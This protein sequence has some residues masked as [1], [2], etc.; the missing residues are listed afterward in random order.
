[1]TNF[2]FLAILDAITDGVITIDESSNVL[3]VNPVAARM[4]GYAPEE[5][6]G[7]NVKLLMPEP[8]A[9][10]HANYVHD[11][12]S[13]GVKHVLASAVKSTACTRVARPSP[14]SCRSAR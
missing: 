13:S 6:L 7:Q 5:L 10:V 9:S 3:S 8:Q 4:F 12:I 2:P 1:M 14:W 11:Y